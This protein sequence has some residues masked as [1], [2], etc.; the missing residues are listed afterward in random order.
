[1]AVLRC[2]ALRR[3]GKACGALAA[4]PTATF[5]RRHEQL[6]AE[7]GEQ[8]VRTGSYPRR[9]VPR[10]ETPLVMSRSPGTTSASTR[11]RSPATHTGGKTTPPTGTQRS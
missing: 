1:M 6:A 10:D 9:R 3:D 4:T 2:A 8:A 11:A 5:C 7:H